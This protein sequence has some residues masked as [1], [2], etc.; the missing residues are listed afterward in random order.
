MKL[1]ARGPLRLCNASDLVLVPLGQRLSIKF[2]IATQPEE[3]ITAVSSSL[4]SIRLSPPLVG[5]DSEIRHYF[6][7][8]LQEV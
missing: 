7:T 2:A 1:K 8:D 3:H 6:W 5:I 4:H